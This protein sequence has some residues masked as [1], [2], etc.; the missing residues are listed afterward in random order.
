MTSHSKMLLS[1]RPQLIPGMS[2]SVC[3]CLSW[4]VSSPPAAVVAM[5]GWRM[6]GWEGQVNSE[7]RRSAGSPPELARSGLT[8]V[9][10][11]ET[12]VR[13]RQSKKRKARMCLPVNL[14][15]C[16]GIGRGNVTPSWSSVT[17]SPLEVTMC[18]GSPCS[19]PTSR[20]MS[21]GAW[22]QVARARCDC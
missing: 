22:V 6:R 8:A 21:P 15:S 17:R 4:R 10:G 7:E 9:L 5:L 20:A 12:L 18:Q 19:R 16:C 14:S 3:I 2:L 13:S 1:A 11:E